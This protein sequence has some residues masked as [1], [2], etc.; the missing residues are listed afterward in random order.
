MTAFTASGASAST[1]KQS[2]RSSRMRKLQL[3]A[4]M[5]RKLELKEHQKPT[6]ISAPSAG[7]GS[8]SRKGAVPSAA[9]VAPI[10][11]AIAYNESNIASITAKVVHQ[12]KDA[13]QL[14]TILSLLDE[15]LRKKQNQK[16]ALFM[17]LKKILLEE[18]KAKAVAAEQEREKAKSEE[19]EEA[20]E[21]VMDV[22]ATGE[23]EGNMEDNL[24]EKDDGTE[25]SFRPQIEEDMDFRR[26]EERFPMGG[27]GFSG[28]PMAVS[29]SSYLQPRSGFDYSPPKNRESEFGAPPH[30]QRAR[31][32]DTGNRQFQ[33]N[34]PPRI[35]AAFSPVRTQYRISHQQSPMMQRPGMQSQQQ[36]DPYQRR[37][38]TTPPR[39]NSG[40]S[41]GNQSPVY[42]NP[43]RNHPDVGRRGGFDRPPPS[44][45]SRR[46]KFGYHMRR[47]G[48]LS[49]RGRGGFDRPPRG[50]GRPIHPRDF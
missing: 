33:S 47:G 30:E 3:R 11:E 34:R 32:F 13:G 14:E 31:L 40:Y 29:G 36:M 28:P 38:S 48:Q 9:A 41:R 4:M 10:P 6:E 20:Q 37:M 43:T 21:E 19:A 2:A 27:Y 44:M 15:D 50:R 42:L 16:H 8:P 45:P 7:V 1:A 5:L 25:P 35:S 17:S 24:P 18:N 23:P 22:N 12:T 39:P 26:K 46:G 49:G